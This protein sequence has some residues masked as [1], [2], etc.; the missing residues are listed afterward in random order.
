MYEKIL[1][2]LNSK[3][4][5]G[6]LNPGV[7][8]GAAIKQIRSKKLMSQESLALQSGLKL[9]MLKSLENGYSQF[10]KMSNL[11]TISKNLKVSLKEILMEAKI[12]HPSHCYPRQNITAVEQAPA[13]IKKTEKHSEFKFFEKTIFNYTNFDLELISPFIG[14]RGHFCWMKLTIAPGKSALNFKLSQPQL[15]SG[16]LAKGSLKIVYEAAEAFCATHEGFLMRGDK[17]HHFINR[18]AES[19]AEIWLA[20]PT[21]YQ[22]GSIAIAKSQKTASFDLPQMI[23]ALKSKFGFSPEKPLASSDLAALIQMDSASL[24]YLEKNQDSDQVIYWDKLEM[25]SSAL[26]ISSSELLDLA[27]GKDDGF[28]FMTHLQ[29][30]A[31]IDYRH[32][33]GIRIKSCL[34][35]SM[36]P[37]VQLMEMEIEAQEQHKQPIWQRKDNGYLAVYVEEGNLEMKLGKHSLVLAKDESCYFNGSLGYKFVNA[38]QGK[39]KALLAAY[40]AITF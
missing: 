31:V 6:V 7:A 36:H 15:V 4:I 17:A 10:T 12:H 8:L 37:K 22:P 9:S 14:S 20:F 24:H 28:L 21:S 13:A 27:E 11:L 1:A 34:A 38:G 18:H 19:S 2:D 16:W 25:M 33:L 5:S 40:P 32:T 23:T 35:P 26:R 39:T 29:D 3:N 30:R